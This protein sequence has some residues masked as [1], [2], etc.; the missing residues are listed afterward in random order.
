VMFVRPSCRR[1]LALATLRESMDAFR[2]TAPP[3]AP[4]AAVSSPPVDGAE[5][6][7]AEKAAVIRIQAVMRG[8]V[9]RAYEGRAVIHPRPFTFVWRIHIGPE[10]H[11]AEW[12][13]ALVWARSHAA[14]GNCCG[15]RR[16]PRWPNSSPRSHEGRLPFCTALFWAYRN[17]PYPQERARLSDRTALV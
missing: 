13:T 4:P 17:L 16:S 15:T 8:K 6:T 10:N 14:P 1:A 7:A 9:A 2:Y 11:S 5:D 3:G 12:Q